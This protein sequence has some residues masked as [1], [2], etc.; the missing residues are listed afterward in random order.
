MAG[1]SPVKATDE[2]KAALKALAGG[3]ERAEADRAREEIA[4][5]RDELSRVAT[6]HQGEV[7]RLTDAHQAAL[8]AERGRAVR[9]ETE[10]DALRSADR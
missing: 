8:E 2:Q 4:R 10:L 7:T 5:L 6:A 1:K 3:V 9:A